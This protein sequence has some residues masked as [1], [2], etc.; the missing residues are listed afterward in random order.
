M[1]EPTDNHRRPHARLPLG[2]TVITAGARRELTDIDVLT[3]LGRHARGDWGDV[4]DEDWM[5]EHMPSED[6]FSLED[7]DERGCEQRF[8]FFRGRDSAMVI[9]RIR[10]KGGRVVSVKQE[11]FIDEDVFEGNP[12]EERW[13][14]RPEGGKSRAKTRRGSRR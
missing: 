10:V 9:Y 6:E 8:N 3:A 12:Q 5:R 7:N 4:D 1:A 11:V 2:R 13:I 14:V